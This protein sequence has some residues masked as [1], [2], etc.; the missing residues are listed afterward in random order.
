M[1]RNSLVLGASL[2]CAILACLPASADDKDKPAL[3]GAWAKKDAEPK[4][5]F[6][7]G[8]SLAIYP[9][10]DGLDFKVACS[11]TVAKDGLVTAK[12]TGLEGKEEVVEKAKGALPVGL[13]FKFKWKVKG[14]SATLDGLEGEGIGHAKDRLEGEY[15]KKS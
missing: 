10:G 11:Y 12:I 7:D 13:E 6:A 2:V 1:P 5:E 3:S 15:S 8:G 14:E 9:H 4:L